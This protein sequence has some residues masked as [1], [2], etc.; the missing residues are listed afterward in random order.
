[1]GSF[2]AAAIGVL[3][4]LVGVLVG[5]YLQ[6]R[7]VKQGE[8][9]LWAVE[10]QRRMMAFRQFLFD[11]RETVERALVT[12]SADERRS[13]LGTGWAYFAQDWKGVRGDAAAYLRL[14]PKVEGK[15]RATLVAQSSALEQAVESRDLYSV[16][17]ALRPLLLTVDLVIQALDE[18]IGLRRE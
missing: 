12:T 16:R 6:G 13:L 3:G 2:E 9:R 10:L 1:L 14:V 18:V 7:I 8:R 4:T 15:F 11:L 17:K 5:A